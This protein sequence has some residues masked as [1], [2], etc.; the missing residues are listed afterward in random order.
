[1][2]LMVRSQKLGWSVFALVF[3]GLA[4]VLLSVLWLTGRDVVEQQREYEDDLLLSTTRSVR[5]MAGDLTEADLKA[6]PGKE[7]ARVK[8]IRTQLEQLVTDLP[9]VDGM[10]IVL[11]RGGRFY[12]LVDASTHSGRKGA[13]PHMTP[14]TD[15]PGEMTRALNEDRSLTTAQPYRDRWAT[16]TS[17]FTPLRNNQSR[18]IGLVRADAIDTGVQTKRGKDRVLLAMALASLVL[19]FV[20]AWLVAGQFSA[21]ERSETFK[22]SRRRLGPEFAVAFTILVVAVDG[23][24][25]VLAWNRLEESKNRTGREAVVLSILSVPLSR[26]NLTRAEIEELRSQVKLA[27]DEPSALGLGKVGSPDRIDQMVVRQ[28]LVGRSRAFTQQHELAQR[29]IDQLDGALFRVLCMSLILGLS[30]LVV[31]RHSTQQEQNL[32]DIVR[33]NEESKAYYANVVQNLPVGLFAVQ[34]G[35]VRFANREWKL[36][37]EL[38]SESPAVEVITPTVH[39]ADRDMLERTLQQAEAGAVPFQTQYRT[40]AQNGAIR[41]YQAQGVPLLRPDGSLEE[42]L[43]FSI[44]I[45]PTVEAQ[46]RMREAYGEVESKNRLL[47]SALSELESNLQSMV[48]ALVRA[49]EAKDPYTAGHSERVM[50]YS[51]WL[52]EAVGM[53]PYELRILE[54]GCLVH[55]VGKIG[56]PDHILTKPG[57]LTDEEFDVI[58][59]H[60]EAGVKIIQDIPMF[61][62]C[63]PVVRWHHERL[64]GRGYPDGLAGDQVSVP[65]R[66]SAI[67]DIFDA[68]TS[69]R[70]Y[71]KGMELDKVLSIMQEVADRGEI[72]AHLFAIFCNVVAQRGIIAQTVMQA[73]H[74]AA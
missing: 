61:R 20:V 70:A 67:A 9:H 57:K 56:I 17:A 23:A 8:R 42:M 64:D 27:G 38:T 46:Q 62:E 65:V 58:K 7:S 36:Q 48:I 54:L 44:D 60:P 22:R 13:L 31:V 59:R 12:S 45:T 41:T 71:R 5:M 47:S 39:P 55:D 37:N 4:S 29:Q 32:R 11:K 19:S 33:E 10:G 16:W 53:G 40:Q 28:S 49:V 72:D 50:Q 26:P 1:M 6:K 63:I 18:V 2:S 14:L 52:G 74:Q 66:I 35:K 69:T 24:S 30:A 51:L 3:V 25:S 21:L 34:Q 15:I 73:P 43:G 68:M